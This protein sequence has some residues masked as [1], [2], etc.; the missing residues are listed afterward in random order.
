MMV[1]GTE[2]AGIVEAIGRG[3]TAFAIGD[4]VFG[5]D[6]GAFGTAR[7]R[8]NSSSIAGSA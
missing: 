5:C 6:E 1:L 4:R 8:C 3:V 7:R 2:Y